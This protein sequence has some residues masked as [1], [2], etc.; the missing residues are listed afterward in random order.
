MAIEPD[1]PVLRDVN[2]DSAAAEASWRL[3]A[4][5]D[6]GKTTLVNLIAR[7][8]DPQVGR[9]LIDGFDVRDVSLASLRTQVGICL[10]GNVPLQRH[11]RGRTL[12]MAGRISPKEKSRPRLDCAG[13]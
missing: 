6:A 8:Y 3:L 5:P 12:H 2:F 4:R 7:F 1:K 11:R 10:S 9:I 13:A